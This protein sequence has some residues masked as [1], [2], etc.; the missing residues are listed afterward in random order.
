VSKEVTMT[1][2]FSIGA[3]ALTLALTVTGCTATG[4]TDAGP[5]GAPSETV[6]SPTSTPTAS[7]TPAAPEVDTL[8]GAPPAGT[9]AAIAWEALMGPDG[10]YAAAASYQAVLDAFGQVEPYAT[11]LEAELR[12]IDALIRQLDRYGVAV[13]PNPYLGVIAAPTDLL[14]AATAWAAGEVNNVA[15][16]DEL[17]QRS[18]DETLDRVLSNLR[19]ASLDS[20]LPLFE[21]AAA[22]GGTLTEE[23]LAQLR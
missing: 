18:T 12:H 6:A 13:P 22:N 19:R 4:L 3:V 1:R 9:D 21:A 2:T 11:I 20:H 8:T 17:L 15:M 16:Y 5:T 14:T 10:E 7:E 23:Q